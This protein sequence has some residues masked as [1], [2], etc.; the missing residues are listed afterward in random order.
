MHVVSFF[1]LCSGD[2]DAEQKKKVTQTVFK[3]QFCKVVER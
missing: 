1:C 3:S 2:A